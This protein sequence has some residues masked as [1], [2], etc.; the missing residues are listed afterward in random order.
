MATTDRPRI[1]VHVSIP[2]V[3]PAAVDGDPPVEDASPVCGWFES[4]WALRQGLAVQELGPSDLPDDGTVAA[5]W[6]AALGAPAAP[7]ACWQ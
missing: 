3:P 1:V 7:S 6:L 4:S 5:L 2:R